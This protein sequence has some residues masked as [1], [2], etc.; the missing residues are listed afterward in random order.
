V[1]R[2]VDHD[3]ALAV[4]DRYGVTEPAVR[5]WLEPAAP[6]APPD[7]AADT[8]VI[9]S[10]TDAVDAAAAMAEAR[11][12]ESC[13]LSTRLERETRDA[14]RFHAAVATDATAG[15]AAGSAPLRRRDGR[16]RPR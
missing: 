7:V 1:P 9:A 12:Y 11:G 10:A 6:R 16:D 8:H 15:R 3:A 13:V 14:G 4:L 5:G 2:P